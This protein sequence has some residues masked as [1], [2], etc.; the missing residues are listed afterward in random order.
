MGVLAAGMLLLGTACKKEQPAA[1]FPAS[2]TLVNGL[3]DNTSYL[4]VYFGSTQ[5]K[6]Y[7]RLMYIGS[8]SYFGYATGETNLPVTLF[9]NNDTLQ[10]NKPFLKTSLPLEAGGIY[11]Y[12]V[13]GSTSD[14]KQKT[15]KEQ[16]PS[17]SLSDS[18]AN[19]RVINLFDN[20]PIDVVELEPVEETLVANLAYEALSDFIKVPANLSVQNFR[21]EVRDHATGA[22][23]TTMSDVNV[24]PGTT[25][26]NTGW[27]FK[28]RTMVVTGT[29]TS[30]SVFS[31]RAKSIG[32]Y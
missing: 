25:T 14:V 23:L 31:A 19:L 12:F 27:L 22:T 17:R 26:L 28:A 30:E 4:T 6:Y 16:L 15:V 20:R 29:W 13:Y 8:G 21:F 3:S 11:T 10:P 2:L 32:H 24:Y 7:A 1:I 5:P 9:R 18:V